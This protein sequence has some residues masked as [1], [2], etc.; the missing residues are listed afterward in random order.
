[1]FSNADDSPMVKDA[2]IGEL[3]L[4]TA[5]RSSDVR[6]ALCAAMLPVSAAASTVSFIV[7]TRWNSWVSGALAVGFLIGAFGVW[8]I[9]ERERGGHRLDGTT[10]DASWRWLQWFAVAVAIGASVLFGLA[11]LRL[12]IGT[13]IS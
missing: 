12:T 10:T 5:R 11:F 8:G 7:L 2:S 6:L 1:M 4:E 3:W 13:W 9:A